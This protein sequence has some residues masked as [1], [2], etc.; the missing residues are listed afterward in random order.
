MQHTFL[1]INKMKNISELHFPA[2]VQIFSISLQ[3]PFQLGEYVGCIF[4][5]LVYEDLGNKP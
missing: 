2:C 5:V 3:K 1:C 4:S